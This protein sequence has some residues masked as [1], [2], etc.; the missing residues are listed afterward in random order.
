M[1]IV[2][3]PFTGTFDF[4]GSEHA[5]VTLAGETYLTLSGQQI[6]AAKVTEAQLNIADNTTGNF[7]TTAHGFVPKGTNVGNFL[8]DDGT[9][10]AVAGGITGSG[11]ANQVAYWSGTSTLTGDANF[12]YD[13]TTVKLATSN[14][15][16]T[17]GHIAV[18]K[19]TVPDV[20]MRLYGTDAA[21]ALSL[22]HASNNALGPEIRLTKA[23][24]DHTTYAATQA[25][26]LLGAVRWRG[27]DTSVTGFFAG[28][29]MEGYATE[30]WS[31]TAHGSKILFATTPNTTISPLTRM[32]IDQ[33]GTVVVG[34]GTHERNLLEVV[35]T[36]GDTIMTVARGTAAQGKVGF[37]FTTTGVLGIGSWMNYLPASS[38]T[39]SWEYFNQG[40]MATLDNTGVFTAKTIIS[41]V[42]TGQGLFLGNSNHGLK[43]SGNDV[44][45]FTTGGNFYVGVVSPSGVP[46][47][48]LHYA[49]GSTLEN[50][51]DLY[52]ANGD[53]TQFKMMKIQR[54]T[55]AVPVNGLGAMVYISQENSALAFADVVGW[56]GIWTN[57][58]STA[59]ESAFNV[60][61]RKAGGALTETFRVQADRVGIGVTTPLAYLHLPA[62]TATAGYAP[63]KFT[64][65]TSLTTAEAGAMEFTTD[66]YFLTITTGAA[67]K[68]IVLN[69]G[70]N[71]TANT[72]P[73]ATTNGRLAD[74]TFTTTTLTSGVYTPTLTN[75][76]NVAASTA[77]ECQY[78]RVGSVVTVSGKVDI[79]IT[80][81]GAYELGLSLPVASNLGAD[82]DC[83]GTGAGANNP[84]GSPIYIKADATN[85]RA[86][87]NGSDT[88]VSNHAHYFT[89]TYQII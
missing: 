36:T 50:P 79:D 67:R 70:T 62:G 10:A 55:T 64:S 74:S 54:K 66:D 57:K 12:T 65:G 68:G 41:G 40:V 2:F 17:T 75:G 43:R 46:K 76:T 32:T 27:Y 1:S 77:Y 26:D 52:G 44:S 16:F 53:N 29:F 80:A 87:L 81:A 73:V 35:N 8:K 13:G 6:T 63:L 72:F 86:S 88:D 82:E 15:T 38:T 30:L 45:L 49:A 7:S 78:I 31:A 5:A 34:N 21:D 83:A 69:D 56:G 84:N 20:M 33:D 9:W 51:L 18:G 59:E 19:D 37:R 25:S 58:N 61:T 60:L 4:K 28:A 14:L 71:L 89:F 85:N 24:G 47:I 48:G 22:R 11:V 39:L 3:N 23:R 42:S